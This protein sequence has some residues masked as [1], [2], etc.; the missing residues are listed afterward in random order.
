MC[1]TVRM[2]D[3]A[4]YG[5]FGALFCSKNV[6]MLVSSVVNVERENADQGKNA[7]AISRFFGG[8]GNCWP[9]SDPVAHGERNQYRV[10]IPKLPP[11]PPETAHHRSLLAP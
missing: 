8:L 3:S 9:G 10:M 5:E 1:G 7:V 4:V 6:P 2:E 11:P